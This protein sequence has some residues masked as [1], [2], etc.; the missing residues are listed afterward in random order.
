MMPSV[1]ASAHGRRIDFGNQRGDKDLK[2]TD[3]CISL[4]DPVTES[5]C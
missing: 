1:V 2:C 4:E 3:I 5:K